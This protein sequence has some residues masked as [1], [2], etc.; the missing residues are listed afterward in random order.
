MAICEGCGFSYQDSF[1]FC[2][3]CGRAKPKYTN[4]TLSTSVVTELECPKCHSDDKVEKIS[5][6]LKAQTHTI[7]GSLPISEVYTNSE[8]EIRTDTSYKKFTS[9][10]LSSLAR[11]V[12]YPP[13]PVIPKKPTIFWL[14]CFSVLTISGICFFLYSFGDL[15]DLW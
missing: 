2:P 5:A 15:L 3:Q 11:S 12:A 6:I 4:V 10:Q 1:Q 9:T 14:L 7:E 8:G 13:Q